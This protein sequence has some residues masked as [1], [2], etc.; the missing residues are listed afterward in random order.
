[1]SSHA[2]TKNKVAMQLLP[3]IINNNKYNGD[4][5]VNQ[6]YKYNSRDNANIQMLITKDNDK[7]VHP[8]HLDPCDILSELELAGKIAEENRRKS[9]EIASKMDHQLFIQLILKYGPLSGLL[10]CISAY[11]GKVYLRLVKY[12]AIK[13]QRWERKYME[14][15]K[16]KIVHSFASVMYFGSDG[17]VHIGITTVIRFREHEIQALQ[18]RKKKQQVE[19]SA[20]VRY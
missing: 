5:S 16:Q 2:T 9:L 8:L 18:Y 3:T 10:Y 1:M 15:R 6:S 14:R 13:I 20:I 7:D 12:C 11:P 4:S 19:L 17:Y